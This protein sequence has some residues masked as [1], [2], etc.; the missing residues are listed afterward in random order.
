[1]KISRA[2]KEI[3]L[4]A[5]SDSLNRSGWDLPVIFLAAVALSSV[6]CSL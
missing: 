3:S 6:P 4:G 1:M 2:R 5:L